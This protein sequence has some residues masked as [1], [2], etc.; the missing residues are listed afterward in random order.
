MSD[1]IKYTKENFLVKF[2]PNRMSKEIRTVKNVAEAIKADPNGLAFYRKQIGEDSV[3]AVIEM[4]LLSLAQSV[5]VHG[6]LSKFQN[7]E[8]AS[9]IITL[10]YFMNMTEITYIFRKAKRGEYGPIKY[11]L[12]MP[13][14]LQWFAQY[15]EERVTHCMK[16][17]EQSNKQRKS[18]HAV[19]DGKLVNQLS[20]RFAPEVLDA[21]G[22]IKDEIPKGF[23]RE[24]FKQWKIDNNL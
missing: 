15:A 10:Y 16:Q 20:K 11:A 6:K 12:N 22:K 19:E 3:I 21:L 9:E 1:L 7:Y 18:E 5:N 23:D 2:E 13:E 8:I 14:V 24:D 4:H 17:T